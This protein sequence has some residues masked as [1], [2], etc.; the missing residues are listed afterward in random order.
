MVA[1]YVMTKGEH[2]FGEEFDRLRNL[3]DDNPVY[4]GKVKNP[5]ARDLISWMLS[6]DPRDRPSAVQAL[7]HPYLL[8]RKERFELLCQV[9]NQQEV[10]T[11]DNNSNVVRQL[12]NDLTDWR[13][14]MSSDVLEYLSTDPSKFRTFRYGSSWTECLRLI[15]NVY[16]HWYDRPRP[17]PQPESFY[18]VGDPQEYFLNIFPSLPVLVHR[19][20][21][22]SNWAE[23]LD[24]QQYFM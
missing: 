15:R 8:S 22:S 11:G 16:H 5:V 21:R 24:L 18:L 1:F 7:K 13:C 2:P 6:H 12:N 20:V 10:K 14:L 3:I 4:L 19:A 17:R 23:R 9:G